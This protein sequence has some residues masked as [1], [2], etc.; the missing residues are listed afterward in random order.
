M[1]QAVTAAGLDCGH[2]TAF[3]DSRHGDGDWQAEASWLAAPHLPLPE[4]HV[5]HLVREPLATIRSWTAVLTRPRRPRRTGRYLTWAAQWCPELT[6]DGDPLI[7][8]A[9]WWVLW[10]GLIEPHADERL[11]LEDATAARVSALVARV[12]GCGQIV[13]LPPPV[14]AGDHTDPPLAWSDVEHVPGL[15]E[16]ASRYG[17]R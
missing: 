6:A 14:R 15:V 5:V 13:D 11:R 17:Y 7:R 16:M 12:T 4:T 10:N 1:A 8:A 2:E 3:T 9:T